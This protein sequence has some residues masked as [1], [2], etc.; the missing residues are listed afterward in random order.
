MLMMMFCLMMV[1]AEWQMSNTGVFQP[2][3][4]REV[5]VRPDGAFYVKNFGDAQVRYFGADGELIKEIGR[6]GKGPG[7]FTYPVDIFFA[8][9]H[10][11]VFDVLTVKISKFNKDGEFIDAVEAPSR[12]IELHKVANGWVY[13]DWGAF[14]RTDEKPVLYWSDPEFKTKKVL[15]E[16]EDAGWS[17]G[18]S[19]TSD[20]THTEATY[21]PLEN[22]PK[23]AVSPDG[24]H[25]YFTSLGGFKI[26]VFDVGTGAK[27]RTIK[28]DEPRIPFDE[29][30]AEEQFMKKSE[31]DR[32]RHKFKKNY[33]EYFPPIRQF[34]TAYDGTLVID[35]WRGR[36]DK[37]NHPLAL[38]PTG[39]EIDLKHNYKTYERI[40]GVHQGSAYVI[41]FNADDEEA[42]VAKC[43]LADVDAFVEANPIKFDGSSGYSISISN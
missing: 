19:I 14:G 33:P 13:G 23:I 25:V 10:L 40:A 3:R 36:P 31:E 39:K 9:G 12:G 15:T 42:G 43:A 30:W 11:Y 32:Q 16:I 1:D 35:R 37:K 6:K 22:R 21:S 29:T 7:E 34:I 24:K 27:V 38:T 2:L 41:I 5:I 18:T 26:H 28:R 4:A 8:D 20:G 17:Q